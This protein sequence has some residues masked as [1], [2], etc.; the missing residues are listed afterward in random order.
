[1]H[2]LTLCPSMSLTYDLNMD[3]SDVSHFSVLKLLMS[4]EFILG[5]PYLPCHTTARTKPAY[6][7]K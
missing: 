7:N 2:N 3:A 5:L 1:M 4:P 6:L